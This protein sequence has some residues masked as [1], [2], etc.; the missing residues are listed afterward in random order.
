MRLRFVNNSVFSYVFVALSGIGANSVFLVPLYAWS[1]GPPAHRIEA[2]CDGTCNAHGNVN[3]DGG[4]V[5]LATTGIT[6]K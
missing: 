6:V 3:R 5:D 1:D 2:S 4:C